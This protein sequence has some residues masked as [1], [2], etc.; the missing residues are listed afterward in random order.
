MKPPPRRLAAPALL[1]L[2]ACRTVAAVPPA[3]PLP[4]LDQRL[5]IVDAGHGGE[6]PGA[7]AS[8]GTREKDLTREIADRLAAELVALGAEVLQSRPGDA[9]VSLDA[10]AQL[11]RDTGCDLLVSVH[12]DAAENSQARGATV[13]V[14]RGALAASE[15]VAEAIERRLAAAQVPSRGVKSSGFRVLMGHPRPSVL[16]ECGFLTHASERAALADPGYQARVA[17]AIAEGVLEALGR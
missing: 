11:A 10:R 6:D 2:A 7:V 13:F 5:V 12:A 9:T 15:R 16:V 4:R 3:P 17:R 14:A 8:D 1:A